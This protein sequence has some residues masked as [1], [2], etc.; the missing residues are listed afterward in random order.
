[1]AYN[2]KMIIANWK[3]NGS[4]LKLEEDLNYYF[5]ELSS[6]LNLVFAMPH[7]FLHQTS[8]MLYNANSGFSLA[9]QDLSRFNGYGSYTGEVSNNLLQEFKVKY[10]LI[11]HSERREFFNENNEVLSSKLANCISHNITPVLCIG[12]SREIR[13]KGSYLDFLSEQLKVLIH[14]NTHFN[15]IIIAY[16]P[17]W[18]IGTGLIP[19]TQEIEEVGAFIHNFMQGNFTHV[20]ISTLYGG[21][22]TERNIDSILTIPTINGVL[23]GGASLD[24]NKFKIICQA[25]AK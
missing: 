12:E 16:E 25:A 3:M 18:A 20:K 14:L 9:T 4:L 6:N 5:K 7:V 8:L 13:E 22:V 2:S 17:I 19:E 15:E 23:V 10:A 21:S 24:R 11:G 1:M